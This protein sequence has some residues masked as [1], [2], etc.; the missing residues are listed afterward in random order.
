MHVKTYGGAGAAAFGW[1]AVGE[2]FN[3]AETVAGGTAAEMAGTAARGAAI[4]V[5]DGIA[6]RR[7]GSSTCKQPRDQDFAQWAKQEMQR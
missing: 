7:A 5:L 4:A 1:R 6:L 2:V 3:G